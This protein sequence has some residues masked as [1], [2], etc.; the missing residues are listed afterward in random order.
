MITIEKNLLSRLKDVFYHLRT[1]DNAVL[2][3]EINNNLDP[4]LKELQKL[5]SKIAQLN[6]IKEKYQELNSKIISN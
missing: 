5:E 3:A 2:I 6:Q 1:S 4:Q